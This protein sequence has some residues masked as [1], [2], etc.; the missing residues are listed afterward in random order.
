MSFVLMDERRDHGGMPRSAR[1][2]S[3]SLSDAVVLRPAVPADDDALARLAALDGRRPLRGPVVVAERDGVA[4]A[5]RAADGTTVA[6]PFAPTA[7]L[8]A[9]LRVHAVSTARPARRRDILRPWG[10]GAR[11]RLALA[12]G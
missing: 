2:L 9:L 6:D 7:D 1:P 4:V 10:A 11:R 12:R 8:V 3:P 5:A